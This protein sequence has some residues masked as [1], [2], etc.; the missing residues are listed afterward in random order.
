LEPSIDW[1]DYN[2]L[3]KGIFYIFL[4]SIVFITL[5]ACNAS[6][7]LDR[8]E[9]KRNQAMMDTLSVVKI[10]KEFNKLFPENHRFISRY[11]L[12]QKE[13][14]FSMTCY[15]YERYIL[16]L[17]MT[18]DFDKD[19]DAVLRFYDEKIIVSEII[20]IVVLPDG[21]YSQRFG[22]TYNIPIKK[23]FKLYKADGDF[24][25]IDMHLK[26]NEP[27]EGFSDYVQKMNED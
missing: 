10:A 21:R 4:S 26:K 15:L 1:F 13:A 5:C 12:D 24:S 16:T 23:W 17:S 8:L 2:R 25:K 3:M 19:N 18:I 6:M 9:Y 7:D 22:N 11:A 14:G 27:V 20:D